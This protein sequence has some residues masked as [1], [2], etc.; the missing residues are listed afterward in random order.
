MVERKTKPALASNRN[1]FEWFHILAIV[2]PITGEP[3][4]G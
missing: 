2:R 1:R 4:G 3:G